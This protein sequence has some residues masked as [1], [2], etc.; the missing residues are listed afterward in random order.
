M[1]RILKV[2]AALGPLSV[3]QISAHA[4]V[5]LN[6][7]DQGGYLQALEDSGQIHLCRWLHD[8]R[9][10]PY[11]VYKK[12]AGER[13]AKPENRPVPKLSPGMQRIVEAIAST[14]PMTYKS[15]AKPAGL[16]PVTIKNARYMERLEAMGK[17]HIAGWQRNR[18]GPM[19]P[20]YDVGAGPR[21]VAPIPFSS[22]EKSQR[23]R[24]KKNLLS[25]A[26]ACVTAQLR[27]IARSRPEISALAA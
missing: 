4:H 22:K 26:S 10:R 11:P 27:A 23:Y 1:Q 5:S 2:L 24:A 9:G 6:T 8:E 20:I 7:L 14:G 3:R 17:L 19:C 21:I 13:A 25:A 12:G 18:R 15:V 16:S